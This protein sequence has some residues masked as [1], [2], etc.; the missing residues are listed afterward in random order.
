MTPEQLAD[1]YSLEILMSALK[2][3][4]AALH[5]ELIKTKLSKFGGEKKRKEK[6][7]IN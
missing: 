3:K 7:I 4:E 5:C 2:K 1:T 6:K